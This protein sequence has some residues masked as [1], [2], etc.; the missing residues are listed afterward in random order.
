MKNVCIRSVSSPPFS[1]I[2][3]EH[4]EILCV[5]LHIQSECLK[6]RIRKTLNTDTIHAVWL[7]HFP[8]LRLGLKHR[9][10]SFS[11]KVVNS[12]KSLQ[13]EAIVRRCSIEK[14]FLEM[15]QNSQEN[16]RKNSFLINLEAFGCTEAAHQRC[17]YKKVFWKY[18]ATLQEKTHAKVPNLSKVVDDTNFGEKPMYLWFYHFWLFIFIKLK[19]IDSGISLILKKEKKQEVHF[20]IYK[21]SFFNQKYELII[22]WVRMECLFNFSQ[23]KKEEWMYFIE[24]LLYLERF[25]R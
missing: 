18:A 23:L 17:S 6:I 3:T 16:T 21:I 12:C 14:V 8:V 15:S 25:K 4:G 24:L 7:L 11:V 5:S 9:W 20:D 10:R 19:L 13:T 1:R 2:Q 22:L